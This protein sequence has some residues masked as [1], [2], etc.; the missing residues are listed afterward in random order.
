MVA[1]LIY[2][3]YHSKFPI[4]PCLTGFSTM[5][6]EPYNWTVVIRG[7]WNQA[8]LT[9][10]WIAREI[11]EV[12]DGTPIQVEVPINLFS[13]PRIKHDNIA[14][15]VRDG[16]L[17]LSV[18]DCSHESL[19]RAREYACRAI[20]ALPI[21][22]MTAAGFNVCY[23]SA[24]VSTDLAD[25]L[26]CKLDNILS[27]RDY[28][29]RERSTGRVLPHEKGVINVHI[30]TS[31]QNGTILSLNFH[32]DETHYEMLLSWLKMESDIIVKHSNSL[33]AIAKGEYT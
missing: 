27:D 14:V 1:S 31:G 20:S 29:I 25:I 5:N 11:F 6:F 30:S 19:T 32:L 21:T 8:I 26:D 17:E 7:S 24:E 16:A 22:P 4:I 18:D 12:S 28:T 15:I 23:K 3:E 13:P 9:P 10:D 2:D 33:L